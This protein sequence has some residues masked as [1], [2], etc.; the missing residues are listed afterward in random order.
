VPI[1]SAHTNRA[2]VISTTDLDHAPEIRAGTSTSVTGA[3]GLTPGV[4]ALLSPNPERASGTGTK[5]KGTLSPVP[6]VNT[7]KQQMRSL[8]TP[9]NVNELEKVPGEHPDRIFVTKLCSYLKTGADFG[10]NVSVLLGFQKV[11]SQL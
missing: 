5:T 1:Q 10:Y 11:Y 3:V 9:I 6:P 7:S 4:T 2:P 8:P